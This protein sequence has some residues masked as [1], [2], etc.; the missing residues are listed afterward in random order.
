MIAALREHFGSSIEIHEPMGGIYVWVS[1]PE[2]VDTAALAPRAA[3]LGIEFNPGAGWS[4]DPGHGGR[5]LR[6]CFGHPTHETI[7][8]GVAALAGVV[9]DQA[10]GVLS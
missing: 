2:Q 10:P 3:E 8:A 9:R 5:R 6:L 1:F 4:A 7:R